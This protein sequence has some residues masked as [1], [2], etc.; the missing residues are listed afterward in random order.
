MP[1]YIQHQQCHDY[2]VIMLHNIVFERTASVLLFRAQALR[3]P[4]V[5]LINNQTRIYMLI[6]FSSQK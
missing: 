6:I 3:F 2:F 4:T 1:L 5:S